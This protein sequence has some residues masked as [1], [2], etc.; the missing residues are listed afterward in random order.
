M[1][2]LRMK[3]RDGC[4]VCHP[5][6]WIGGQPSN[7]VR[8]RR[9]G[10]L[11]AGGKLYELRRRMSTVKTALEVTGAMRLVAAAR[12]KRTADAALKSRPFVQSLQQVLGTV[13]H[14]LNSDGKSF[15][16]LADDAIR[17]GGEIDTVDQYMLRK[18]HRALQDPGT[19]RR[20]LLIVIAGDRGLCGVYNR[21]VFNTA[22]RR[23][24]DLTQLGMEV[25]L[26]CVGRLT[27][28]YFRKKYP[29]LLIVNAFLLG[30]SKGIPDLSLKLAEE[31]L[32][33]FVSDEVDRVELVYTRF[34]SMLASKPSIRTLLPLT[35]LG[36]EWDEDEIFQLVPS[37]HGF[38]VERKHCNPDE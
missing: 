23:I 20:V 22:S 28:R 2:P 32:I 15:E 10:P 34:Q 26:C 17:L 6:G 29:H 1:S 38:D 37:D 19:T 7:L 4:F 33:D 35:P 11:M 16:K 14:R 3:D 30:G 12:I 21:L 5:S 8:R 24:E 27:E 31:S 18:I 9:P 36:F 25:E 13:L